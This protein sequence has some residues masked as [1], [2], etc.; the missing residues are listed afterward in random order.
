V[1]SSLSHIADECSEHDHSRSYTATKPLGNSETCGS[2]E[3]K[4]DYYY[5]YKQQYMNRVMIRIQLKQMNTAPLY[6]IKKMI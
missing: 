3:E 2:L 5:Y 1:K 6:K 4:E